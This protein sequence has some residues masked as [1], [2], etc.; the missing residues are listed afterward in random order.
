MKICTH[1]EIL[2]E[3]L[4]PIKKLSRSVPLRNMNCNTFEPIETNFISP[5][6][7]DDYLDALFQCS[8]NSQ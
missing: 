2:K 6:P 1:Q 7:S 8:S 4:E 5:Y 3:K